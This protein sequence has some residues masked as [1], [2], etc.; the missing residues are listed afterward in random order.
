MT[1]D[2]TTPNIRE[3]L[4]HTTDE[5]VTLHNPQPSL[6]T[7][8][9]ITFITSHIAAVNLEKELFR[10]EVLMKCGTTLTEKFDGA[11]Q[12]EFNYKMIVDAWGASI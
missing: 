7:I 3:A 8:G 1:N 11:K 4:R 6:I 10:V 12:A 9:S 2:K 5:P